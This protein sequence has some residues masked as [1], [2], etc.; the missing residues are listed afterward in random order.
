MYLRFTFSQDELIVIYLKR[1]LL[2]II[3]NKDLNQL[4]FL[5]RIVF[6]RNYN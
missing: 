3:N 2:L 1:P 6:L 5:N 4:I